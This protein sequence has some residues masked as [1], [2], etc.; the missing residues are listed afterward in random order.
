MKYTFF[1]FYGFRHLMKVLYSGDELYECES[2]G[3]CRSLQSSPSFDTV[4]LS[5]GLEEVRV[6]LATSLGYRLCAYICLEELKCATF[7][8]TTTIQLIWV[9]NGK[10]IEISRKTDCHCF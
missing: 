3:G 6:L 8:P 7:E 4:N 9:V 10:L 5:G 1:M 2:R